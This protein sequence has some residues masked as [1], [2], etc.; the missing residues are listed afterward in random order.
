MSFSGVHDDKR[1]GIAIHVGPLSDNIRKQA[2]V[3]PSGSICAEIVTEVLSVTPHRERRRN[4]RLPPKFVHDDG[5]S[6]CTRHHNDYLTRL[7][8]EAERAH[9]E[10]ARPAQ[11]AA[12]ETFEKDHAQ[13]PCRACGHAYNLHLQHDCQHVWNYNCGRDGHWRCDEPLCGCGLPP[14]TV[15]VPRF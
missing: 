10:A 15:F 5:M 8:R 4:C 12:I 11:R 1:R 9:W 13:D 14:R 2:G 6:Y 3:K 7:E